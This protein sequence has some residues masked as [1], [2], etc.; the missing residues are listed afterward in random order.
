MSPVVLVGAAA[1]IDG[2]QSRR[3]SGA[4]SDVHALAW[5]RRQLLKTF[6]ESLISPRV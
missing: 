1:L 5:N 3:T 4:N 6:P 2:L